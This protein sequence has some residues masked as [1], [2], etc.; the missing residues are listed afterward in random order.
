MVKV[1]ATVD[2]GNLRNAF[3]HLKAKGKESLMRRMLV[4]G[5]VLLR[6][7]AKSN[8]MVAANKEGV[9]L[10]GVVANAIYLAQ[11]KRTTTETI[12]NYTISW[13]ARKAPH[14]HLV[15]FGHWQPHPVYKGTDGNWYTRTDIVLPK[16][17]WVAARPF[18]RPTIDS[19]GNTAVKVMIARGVK[20]F[21]ILL[22]EAANA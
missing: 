5:G 12:F 20:E 8:A 7:A 1:T 10:R 14:G 3:A 21:P 18:L 17:V 6:D 11:D 9:P 19:Y 13:N 15:E 22:R 4:E 16:P 2:D